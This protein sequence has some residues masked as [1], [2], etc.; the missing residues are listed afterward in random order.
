MIN[1]SHAGR[2]IFCIAN[3]GF[4]LILIIVCIYPIWYIL[5]QSL[6]GSIV[7]GK[8]L[9][10]PYQFTLGNYQQIFHLP[11]VLHAVFIS[12]AR[13]IIGTGLTTTCCMLLGY[14]FSK[15]DMPCRKLLYRTLTITMYVSGWLIPTYLVI[16]SYMLLNTFWVYILPSVI[17]AYYVILI[18]TY[19]EQLPASVEESAMID[20]AGILTIFFRI[21]LPMS[22][23]II[24]TI[25]VYGSVAQWNAWFDNHIYT[26]A[27]D[28]LTTMQYLL[29]NYLNEAEQ[30]ATMIAET[31]YDI[32]I[33]NQITP[34]SLRMTMTM[35]T[36]F[37]VLL[38]YPFLQRF[39]IKGIMIG[40]VK[41]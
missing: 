16:K 41:G 8:A 20:G 14:L 13:T 36:V 25:M 10:I 15:Q 29:Y 2:R 40:A 28:E 35:I 38:F 4:F 1:T 22:L 26:F 9:W 24:A 7:P 17:S 5:I 30:L 33:A 21:I 3:I 11:G 32:D 39:F 27:V 34:K 19:V 23:P 6:S 31:S 18:K 12:F 37:P